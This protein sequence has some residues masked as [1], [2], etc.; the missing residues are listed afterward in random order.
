[1]T[2]SPQRP[3]SLQPDAPSDPAAVI[4][5]DTFPQLVL[6]PE[7]VQTVEESTETDPP[8]EAASPVEPLQ[9]T[10]T[11]PPPPPDSTEAAL[12]V[13]TPTATPDST[14][15]ALPSPSQTRPSQTS[16]QDIAH[17]Q[18][19]EHPLQKPDTAIPD[20]TDKVQTPATIQSKDNG[21]GTENLERLAPPPIV[22]P[23]TA[24]QRLDTPEESPV[25]PDWDIAETVQQQPKPAGP[26]AQPPDAQSPAAQPPVQ[27]S[28]HEAETQT[29]EELPP[30][31]RRSLGTVHPNTETPTPSTEV[32]PVEPVA[33][34][35]ISPQTDPASPPAQFPPKAAPS[36]PADVSTA[37]PS[38]SASPL[39]KTLPDRP[40]VASETPI[41]D[42]RSDQIT[43]Y[44]ITGSD[45]ER[46]R[47]KGEP[48][49]P[50]LPAVHRV[51]LGQT[52]S[53]VPLTRSADVDLSGMSTISPEPTPTKVSQTG[54]TQS[55]L[56]PTEKTDPIQ[57]RAAPQQFEVQ[58]PDV[59]EGS[60]ADLEPEPE[61]WIA[62]F[63]LEPPKSK[64]PASFLLPDR[65]EETVLPQ[66]GAVEGEAEETVA[67]KLPGE[68]DI[69]SQ[70]PEGITVVSPFAMQQASS[71]EEQLEHLAQLMYGQLR[72]HL[73][74]LHE[75]RHGRAVPLATTVTAV[76]PL[77]LHQLATVVRQLVES[78]L[79]SDQERRPIHHR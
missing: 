55:F 34:R 77:P 57:K 28:P 46:E 51:P 12:P 9:S 20:A 67:I 23:P 38:P 61:P 65:P 22:E 13:V 70:I 44:Q 79:R 76:W 24:P 19:L 25:A 56:N 59:L 4:D 58:Q 17:R 36:P 41:Q 35:A 33:P 40:S 75:S 30:I 71:D 64:T 1:S 3:V 48:E 8:S 2:P 29:L 63:N 27:D 66:I 53:I 6:T 43:G 49:Q 18:P 60:K 73:H 7:T 47:G 21:L 45:G 10:D 39:P 72:S 5:S 26:A 16:A 31:Q 78:R 69:A 37:G 42:G 68:L 62:Q 50:T 32:T 54:E 52:A 14:Q 74:Q 11:P 15:A